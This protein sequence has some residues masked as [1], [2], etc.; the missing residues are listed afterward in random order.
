MGA[1]GRLR[2]RAQPCPRPNHT[3]SPPG[4]ERALPEQELFCPRVWASPLPAQCRQEVKSP[5]V[6]LDSPEV[7]R[8]RHTASGAPYP[9]TSLSPELLLWTEA[10]RPTELLGPPPLDGMNSWAYLRAYTAA[11]STSRNLPSSV[12]CLGGWPPGGLGGGRRHCL[13][14]LGFLTTGS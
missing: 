6:N 11:E 1:I 8:C 10:V 9:G 14:I 4:P 12:L 3:W 7:M 13:P 2:R 5:M